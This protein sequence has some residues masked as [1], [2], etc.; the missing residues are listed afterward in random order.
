M[1]TDIEQQQGSRLKTLI[2]K[3]KE[4][5]FLTYAA[6]NDHL[7]DNI[8]DSD[9]IEDII[10]L[11]NDLGITIYEEAPDPDDLLTS[12]ENTA[13]DVAAEEATATLVAVE[14]EG[15][16]TLD[17]VRM[18]MREMGSVEL[19]TR[20]GGVAIAK[21]I[22]EGTRD[23]LS[24]LAGFPGPV[25]YVLE[26][27]R[28][29]KNGSGLS[30]ILVGS[31]DPMDVVRRPPPFDPTAQA[32]LEDDEDDKKKGPDL[33]QANKRFG[34]LKRAYHDARETIAAEGRASTKSQCALKKLG[35]AFSPFKLVPRHYDEIVSMV[36]DTLT[37]VQQQ[38]RMIMTLCVRESRMPRKLF[39]QEFQ[40]NELSNRWVNRQIRGGHAYSE[41][42][43]RVKDGI[44]RAQN[45]LK[46][47]VHETGLSVTEIKDIN[48]RISLGEAKTR[49]AKTEMVE[50][51]L[52]LVI[53][54]SKKYMNRGLSFLDLIQE[55]NIGL[56]KAVDKFEYRHGLKFSTHATW[57]IRQAITRSIAD[58][59]RTIRVPGHMIEMM[60]KL[61]RMS[62][63]MLQEMGREATPE[64]LAI[65]AGIKQITDFYSQRPSTT[66]R[67]DQGLR[68]A[69]NSPHDRPH[70]VVALPDHPTSA[71][72][73]H[74]SDSATRRNAHQ[75]RK[76]DHPDPK[77][78]N[79]PNTNGIVRGPDIAEWMDRARADLQPGRAWQCFPQRRSSSRSLL[80]CHLRSSDRPLRR[81][82]STESG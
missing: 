45:K 30:H 51:N 33:V 81:S 46:V 63:H 62:R 76:G 49:H 18:Y 78:E 3:G 8:S 39:L 53:A 41:R 61:N 42:L 16:R 75:R 67:D 17:P 59:A 82:T 20:E 72:R 47:I 65:P 7:P 44:I 31:L 21:R 56:M 50:A 66:P 29:A 71:P 23:V 2:A 10:R 79:R 54:I 77:R 73:A 27:Y 60:S 4:R 19:L 38:E 64:E 9:Q 68:F 40:G 35:V 48:R 12:T 5:G 80:G 32:T 34:I 26:R 70:A 6:V 55:G 52:R 57:W 36:R 37:R 14:S 1:A 13:D 74:R 11:T 22:E 69:A 43:A 58:Q 15:R 24:A 25:E 28:E